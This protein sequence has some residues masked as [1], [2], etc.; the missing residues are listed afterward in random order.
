MGAQQNGEAKALAFA[1]EKGA[2]CVVIRLIELSSSPQEFRAAQSFAKG[3]R[4]G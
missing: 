2:Q 3:R 4:T 1:F